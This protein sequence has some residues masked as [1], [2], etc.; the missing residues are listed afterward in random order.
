MSG[1]AHP[2]WRDLLQ[3]DGKKKI[4]GSA[5]NA[6]VVIAHDPELSG[7]FA[8]NVFTGRDLIL[9]PLPTAINGYGEQPGPYP[10]PFAEN[11]V[12]LVQAYLSTEYN[13]RFG[14][15][16]TQRA[17]ATI[18]AAASYHPVVDWLGTLQWDGQPRVDGW[19]TKA[20]GADRTDYTTAAGTKFLIAAVRR[21]MHPGCQF[22]H[23]LVVEGLQGIGKSTTFRT[24]FGDA[25]FTDQI[26]HDLGNKDASQGL[27]GKWGIEFS[28][29]EQL[30]SRR[31]E[32]ET[33]KAFITRRIDWFRPPYGRGFVEQPRQ[34]VLTGTTNRRDWL[35]ADE[36]GNRRFWP[37]AGT[38]ADPAWVAETREQLWAEAAARESAG[39]AIW[40]DDPDIA[41]AARSEQDERHDEDPWTAPVRSFLLGKTEFLMPELL[42][43]LG[44]PTRDQGR[45]EQMRAGKVVRNLGW[46]TVTLWNGNSQS[47]QRVWKRPHII[48]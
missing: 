18:A 37:I 23:M 35:S 17:I 5:H 42:S 30:T 48:V 19:L 2:Q 47:T 1:T 11:D 28:D 14:F 32:I 21:V 36:T 26:P 38:H 6:L 9:R 24:L 12:F 3:R 16:M 39:E 34:C 29:I 10:R 7:I 25:W 4:L 15:E 45:A 27:L 33:I 22:D 13:P 41:A 31:A 8:R 40:L 44:I 43:D 46:F 20:F